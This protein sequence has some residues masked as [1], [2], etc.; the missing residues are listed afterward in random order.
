MPGCSRSERRTER[1]FA[2]STSHRLG[3]REATNMH[4]YPMLRSLCDV[5]FGWTRRNARNHFRQQIEQAALTSLHWRTRRRIYGR[6]SLRHS[7]GGT[8]A[9]RRTAT[10][11][12]YVQTA[13]ATRRHDSG[14]TSRS[15]ITAR[16]C[17]TIDAAAMETR[18]SNQI[19]REM[20]PS[21]CFTTT[22]HRRP[23]NTALDS[24]GRVSDSR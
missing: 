1:F 21:A 13:D 7:P 12:D 14:G 24:M 2:A 22:H 4:L 8:S 6:Q 20:R 19:S 5:L 23:L 17:R 15:R 11:L 18:L 16:S 3:L 10:I 9:N